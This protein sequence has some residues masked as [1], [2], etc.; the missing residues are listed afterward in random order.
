MGTKDLAKITEPPAKVAATS[1]QYNDIIDSFSGRLVHRDANGNV[2]DGGHDIGGPGE[3][4]RYDNIHLKEGMTINGLAI[5]F[6]ELALAPTFIASAKAKSSGFPDF[7]QAGGGANRYFNI[8]ATATNLNVYIDSVNYPLKIDRQSDTLDVADVDSIYVNDATLSDQEYTK[9]IGEYGDSITVETTGAGAIYDLD[10]TIQCFKL[11]TGAGYEIFIA[12]VDLTNDRIIPILRGVGGTERIVFADGDIITLLKAHYIFLDKDLSTISTTTNYP[13]WE[14][15]DPSG[16]VANDYYKKS[17][18][19][20]WYTYSGATWEALGRIYLGYAICDGTGCIGVEHAPIEYKW[21]KGKD[22]LGDVDIT[23]AQIELF[24]SI[25][26]NVVE[27]NIEMKS[28]QT[29]N[30]DNLE[31]GAEA[32]TTWYYLYVNNEGRFYLSN[33][34]PRR[35]DERLGA[36]HP[37]ENWKCIDIFYNN[38]S[39][40]LTQFRTQSLLNIKLS[41]EYFLKKSPDFANVMIGG[42]VPWHKDFAGVPDLPSEFL[43]CN[44]QLITDTASPMYNQTLPDLNGEGRFLRGSATSGT[45]QSSQNKS[46]THTGGTHNHAISFNTQ[47]QNANHAH[48]VGYT[49]YGLQAGSTTRSHP[50]GLP[51]SGNVVS[52]DNTADHIHSVIGNTA[53]D[54]A[55]ATSTGTADGSEARPDNMSVV[56]TMR[57]K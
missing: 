48:T 41:Q 57:V 49:N 13:K 5:D 45:E 11:T 27:M 10:G 55:V 32:G 7:L 52:S 39:S 50:S 12:K 51:G 14:D 23:D 20:K 30:W 34:V 40:N 18:D 44:G 43:E 56:W 8:L 28:I 35:Y 16:A 6:S 25:K 29:I 9:V 33:K 22:I 38:A 46:H 31:S 54:G 53:D 42:L 2:Q 47:I 1:T 36:Y 17:S 15:L 19:R 37:S 26:V 24:P 21:K 4:G 3:A